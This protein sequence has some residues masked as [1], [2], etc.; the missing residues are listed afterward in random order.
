MSNLELF[1][2]V[3]DPLTIETLKRIIELY[4]LNPNFHT[5][6]MSANKRNNSRINYFDKKNLEDSMFAS[7]KKD[8]LALTQDDIK[9]LY[10][11]IKIEKD[12]IKLR[13]FVAKHQDIYDHGDFISAI[14]KEGLRTVYEAYRWDSKGSSDNGWI[15]INS[16][17]IHKYKEEPFKISHNLFINTNSDD[18][19][20]MA[21]L[22]RKKCEEEKLPYLFKVSE[23]PFRDDSIV[24]Y[25]SDDYLDSYLNIL[26]DIKKENP[27]LVSRI[28]N[29]PIL[30]AKVD[31]FGYGAAPSRSEDGR[32]RSYNVVR[33]NIIE[34]IIAEKGREWFY[35]NRNLTLGEVSIMDAIVKECSDRV[36]ATMKKNYANALEYEKEYAK[37]YNVSF[38]EAIVYSKLGY[39]QDQLK[40]YDFGK[41]IIQTIK[42]NMERVL[43]DDKIF[44][45]HPLKNAFDIPLDYG[46]SYSVNYGDVTRIIKRSVV[47]ITKFD[48]NFIKNVMASIRGKYYS[49]EIQEKNF[50][51]SKRF[52]LDSLKSHSSKESKRIY[53]GKL[54][55]PEFEEL[56]NLALNYKVEYDKDIN[57]L[58]VYNTKLKNKKPEED[59][60]VAQDALFAN[61]WLNSVGI[62]TKEGEIKPGITSAFGKNGELLYK[63]FIKGSEHSI[64]KTGNLNSLF[65]FKNA[66]KLK[67]KDAN[68]IIVNLFNNDYQTIFVDNYV[69]NRVD[70]SKPR[71]KGAEA[72]YTFENAEKKL[73]EKT[74]KDD[75]ET[76]DNK[77]AKK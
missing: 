8:V 2:S 77:G 49:E 72:L 37:K 11:E 74:K 57:K 36:F 23:S 3:T 67:M 16:N 75:S 51:F 62:T 33:S 42:I 10:Q 66:T 19:Y 1:D 17:K 21:D 9:K 12:F 71:T 13:N 32:N 54:D 41:K 4:S 56:K 35:K 25:S 76:P 69:H 34:K 43:A 58:V 60:A 53:I 59:I 7:W 27:D 39:T 52:D 26:E 73:E 29:P 31:Y 15:Y 30:S 46:K 38:N 5:S 45:K 70:S 63:Y 44:S 14:N 20:M 48:P 6:L 55:W 50:A 18:T 65:L 61:I 64:S 40:D 22:F 47:G 68:K 28:N 24:I